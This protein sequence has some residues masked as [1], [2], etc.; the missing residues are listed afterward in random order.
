MANRA[1][2][3]EREQIVHRFE[4][5]TPRERDVLKP[6]M[7]GHSKKAMASD[8]LLSQRTIELY[9]AR[10]MEKTARGLWHNWSVWPWSSR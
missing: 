1:D 4:S 6:I 2:L 3:L 8:L 10:V 7:A 9:R 5:L